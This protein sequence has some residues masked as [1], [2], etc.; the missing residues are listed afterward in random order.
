MSTLSN[1]PTSAANP[2]AASMSENQSAD[3]DYPSCTQ[4]PYHSATSAEENNAQS[5]ISFG[6]PH[7][8]DLSPMDPLPHLQMLNLTAA[9]PTT[10]SVHSASPLS[11]CRAGA[12][13]QWD[14]MDAFTLHT[15]AKGLVSTIKKHEILHQSIVAHLESH[16]K[17]L[18]ERVRHYTNTFDRC[19]DNYKENVHYP[20][21]KVPVGEGLFCKVK[22]V[23]CINPQTIL[24]YTAE[25]SP[26]STPHI[27]KIYAQPVML[28]NPVEPLP[29]WFCHTLTGPSAAYHT[30]C[31]AAQDLNDWGVQADLDCYCN[32]NNA[33]CQSLAEAKKCQADAD[34]YRIAKGLCKARLEAARAASSLAHME[35][36]T[37]HAWRPR[38]ASR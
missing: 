3:H 13:L 30:L 8:V 25:D 7:V 24:C 33:L 29:A 19:L 15:I 17:N 10:T 14:D 11:P 38:G 5:T 36:L 34:R 16:I 18:E 2:S 22:W 37:P 20:G 6:V 27:L 12:I 21:L 9:N 26:S 31:Q 4:S 1:T 23:K 32:L 35:G 28:T